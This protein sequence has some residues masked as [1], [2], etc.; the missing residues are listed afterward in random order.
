MTE[1]IELGNAR[2][3]K[4]VIKNVN[5]HDSDVCILSLNDGKVK[6]L[7]PIEALFIF[8]DM[9]HKYRKD[10]NNDKS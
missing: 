7:I 6:I 2:L 10:H 9:I 1:Y 8:E 3:G 5:C 4:H